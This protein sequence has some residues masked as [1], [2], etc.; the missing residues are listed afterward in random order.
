MTVRFGMYFIGVRQ[1]EIKQRFHSYD[2]G[3][4][5]STFFTNVENTLNLQTEPTPAANSLVDQFTLKI[6]YDQFYVE[7]P[8]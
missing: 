6:H 7:T 8:L 5:N 1:C 3:S 2:D 4:S